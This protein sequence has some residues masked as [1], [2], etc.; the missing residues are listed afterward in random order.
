MSTEVM[1][2]DNNIDLSGIELEEQSKEELIDLLTRLRDRRTEL[3]KKASEL[4]SNRDEL[5]SEV[6]SLTSEA[7][8]YKGRRDELNENVRYHKQHRNNL[9]Q[10]A[11]ELDSLADV[12]DLPDVDDE[13]I[14]DIEEDIEDLEFKQ[15]TEVLDNEE[16]R[17]LVSKIETKRDRL[18]ELRV[19]QR[20]SELSDVISSTVEQ[21]R[22]S[23][24]K[25]HEKM[26]EL[27]EKAQ[28]AHEDMIELF[29]EA[30]EVRE[31]ADEYHDNFV[32]IQEAADLH[33]Q[34]LVEVHQE[35][36]DREPEDG[37]DFATEEHDELEE[38]YE[39]FQ[40]GETI[41]DSDLLEAQKE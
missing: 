40:R 30:D 19:I 33:H 4:A 26:I 5:N 6:S 10:R 12:E 20:R 18:D 14:Q 3:N 1:N 31:E 7:N 37:E 35:L 32:V 9:N 36:D 27:A 21:I 38:I 25:H 34:R 16:E 28:E 41:T 24:T 39:K 22:E 17:E 11:N 13:D 8:E 15:Q 2:E 23:A 29:E